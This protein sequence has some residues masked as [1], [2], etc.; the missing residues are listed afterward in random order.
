MIYPIVVGYY[1]HI[2]TGVMGQN[3]IA[4]ALE[5]NKTESNIPVQ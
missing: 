3:Q 1:T 5:P 2:N 4:I